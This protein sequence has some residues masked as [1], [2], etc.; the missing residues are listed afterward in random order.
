MLKR[1]RGQSP[2][3]RGQFWKGGAELVCQPYRK[4]ASCVVRFRPY[5]ATSER[6]A[7]RILSAANFRPH[8]GHEA[9]VLAT[10][11]KPILWP[12]GSGASSSPRARRWPRPGRIPESAAEAPFPPRLAITP[13]RRVASHW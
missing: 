1:S 8:I 7:D 6:S 13:A 2:A 3:A 10:D 9:R 5:V 11:R 4:G 12:R